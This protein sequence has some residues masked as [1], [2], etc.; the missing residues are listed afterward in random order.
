M[1]TNS[2][3]IISAHYSNEDHTAVTIVTKE[4]GHVLVSKRDRPELWAKLMLS[5]VPIA[6]MPDQTKTIDPGQPTVLSDGS[7]N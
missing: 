5:G 6:G 4:A 3:T 1:T 2:Y 7:D